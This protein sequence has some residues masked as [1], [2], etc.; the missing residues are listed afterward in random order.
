MKNKL[1]KI[2]DK[3]FTSNNLCTNEEQVISLVNQNDLMLHS[4]STQE[5]TLEIPFAESLYRVSA[6]INSN[7]NVIIVNK[8]N[9]IISV[10]T[11]RVS[12]LKGKYLISNQL[13]ENHEI[14]NTRI[15]CVDDLIL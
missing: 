12:E 14:F 9:N 15:L 2:L 4:N 6:N 11:Y 10:F 7:D 3:V 8:E 5:K 13:T 1:S